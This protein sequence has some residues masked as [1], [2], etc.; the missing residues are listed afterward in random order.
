M[1]TE[2]TRVIVPN[3]TIRDAIIAIL[4]GVLVLGFVV[5]GIAKMSA[6]PRQNLL[7]GKV[8]SKRFIPA[9]EELISIGSKGLKSKSV[10]GE[11]ILDVKV[12]AENRTFEVPVD[13]ATF[14]AKKEGEVQTFMRPRSEQR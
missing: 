6:E 11:Y 3:T 14:E 10:E 2:N 5:Y 1:K 13:K 8:V 9:K 12:D 4:C 7:T